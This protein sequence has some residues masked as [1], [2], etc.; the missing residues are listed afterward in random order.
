MQAISGSGR[1]LK[2]VP[3]IHD[4]VI[5][6]KGEE[7]KSEIEPV[8][9]LGSLKNNRIEPSTIVITAHCNRVPANDGHMAV[10]SVKFRKK[11]G[12]EEVLERIKNWT[13]E[14]QKLGLPS[15]PSPVLVYLEEDDRP[16]TRLDRDCQKGMGIAVGRLRD[17]KL[18][19]YRFMAL[20]HNLVR[21]A[22]GGAILTAELL[23]AKGYY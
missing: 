21:G 5:P 18:L 19:D 4:N 11:P 14:P 2:D 13:P 7:E 6:L 1:L 22:A 15:A 23:H 12:R 9:I 20:S 17:C 10:V 8:K 16:Q 3:E